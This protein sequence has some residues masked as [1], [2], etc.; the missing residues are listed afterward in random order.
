[1]KRINYILAA[2]AVASLVFTTDSCKKD[3]G[4]VTPPV[5][6]LEE[7]EEGDEFLIGG[8]HGMH[9]ECDFSDNVALASYKIDIHYNDGEYAHEHSKAVENLFSFQ[10][11]YTDIAGKKNAHVHQHD[12]VIPETAPEGK[13]HLMVYCTDEAGNESY[14]VRNIVFSHDAEEHEHE[15]EH[16]D[17]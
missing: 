13:Y 8:E 3:E 6:S 4:D 2:V 9:F 14:I 7:P 15:H 12:V 11:T 10:K 17:E 16:D 5:I 1:M